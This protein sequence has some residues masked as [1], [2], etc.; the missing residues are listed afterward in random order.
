MPGL[1]TMPVQ[2][3]ARK[4]TVWQGSKFIAKAASHSLA[5]RIARALNALRATAE[6]EKRPS[7]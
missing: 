7:S 1:K 4:D 6:F 3:V 5:K 2:F